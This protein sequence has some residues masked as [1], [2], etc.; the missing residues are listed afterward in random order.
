MANTHCTAVLQAVWPHSGHYRPTEEN[1]KDF[2]SFLE[3]NNVDISDVQVKKKL[4]FLLK[5]VFF[6]VS[7]CNYP[8][9]N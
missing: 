2:I 5:R 9:K 8:K 3:E 4:L 6:F 1:F 7:V